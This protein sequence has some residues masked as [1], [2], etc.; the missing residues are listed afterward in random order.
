MA[1]HD[2]IQAAISLY[3][4]ADK[5]AEKGDPIYG[6]L[7]LLFLL[8]LSTLPL[9]AEQL[10]CDG[11]LDHIASASL[12]TYI[13]RPNVSPFADSV[14]PQRCY[15]IWAKG[16]VPILL[17]MMS[18][19]GATIAPEVAYVLNQFPNLM[20]SSIDRFEA[21]DDNQRRRPR[22]PAFITPLSVS[23]IH[24]L[25]LITQVLGALRTK[26]VRD[27]PAVEWDSATL[28]ENVDWWID[29]RKVL[30]ERLVALGPREAEWKSMPASDADK[31]KGS[32]SR[33]EAKVIDQLEFVRTVLDEGLE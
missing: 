22:D 29:H 27:I 1:A 23:E 15:N 17:N 2:A 10:A 26:N 7:A 14:G 33:L 16:I 4:W 31:K 30:R 25:A 32:E 28:L 20:Q 3:S 18:A 19:L 8:E 11:L 12:A 9:V 24:S 5:L 21:P 13:R 6:E